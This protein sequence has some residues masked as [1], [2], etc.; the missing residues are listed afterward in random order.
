M[1]IPDEVA[2][3]QNE[4]L[5]RGHF[6]TLAEG[7]RIFVMQEGNGP[8]LV[9][10]HGFPSTSHDFAAAL[11]MLTSR[12]RVT[13]WDQL[14]FG[15]S[16]KP[17]DEQVSYSL[18]DQGRR[19]GEIARALGI[20]HARVIGHDMG[21]TVAVEMLCRH[22]EHS[23][24]FT[25]DALGLCNGSHLVELAHLTPVQEAL[26]T[27]EG[28]AAFAQNYDPERFADGLRF[29]WADPQRTPAVDIRAIAYW[30]QHNNGLAILG[31]IARYNIE[32]RLYAE[33]WR[34]I[35]GH[36]DVPIRV[37]WG[38]R[39]PIAVI[40]IGRQLSTMSGGTLSVLEGVGHYPQMERPAAWVSAVTSEW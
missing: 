4:W 34:S 1:S 14:G 26:M 13:T 20:T 11:P 31:R 25:I 27:D 30:M 28:A 37:V 29:V 3:V 7:H 8:D 36:T 10:V 17:V 9:L 35:L 23:L 2:R 38:D 39:D 19:A 15:F 5:R 24:G 33:R 21:L 6:T 12:F 32:R 22:H 18:L 40:E 16:D